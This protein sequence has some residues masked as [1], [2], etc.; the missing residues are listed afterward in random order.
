M[1]PGSAAQLKWDGYRALAGRWA[2]GSVA[3]RSRRGSDLREAFPEITEAVRQL[4]GNTALDCE[5]VLWEGSR[6]AFERLQQRMRRPGAAAA[7]AAA[8]FPA[9]L[10]TF[11]VLRHAGQDLTRRPFAE[12]QTALETL[13]LEGGL[14]APWTLCPEHD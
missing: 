6:L 2:D 14:T 1:P 11:D 13:F 9:H 3:T 5:L 4:R 8:E 7:R 10:V 12:R